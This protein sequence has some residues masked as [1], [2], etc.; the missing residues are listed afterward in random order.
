MMVSSLAVIL[1]MRIDVVMLRSMKG[2]AAALQTQVQ[3]ATANIFSRPRRSVASIFSLINAQVS[4]TS[5]NQTTVFSSPL[6]DVS[7]QREILPV[8]FDKC[9]TSNATD[10]PG[11]V[12]I[13]TAP[14]AVLATLPG[15]SDYVDV[16]LERRPAPNSQEAADP[17]YATPTWLVTDASLKPETLQTS[18]RYITSRSQ[19]YRVHSVGYFDGPGPTVRIEAVIDTNGGKPRIIYYR[20]LT[21]LGQAYGK[22]LKGQ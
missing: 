18:E 4:V 10:L 17:V 7:K 22:E 13:N 14:R 21:E 5:N 19:V 1:Y 16:L 8:L 9:T 12:N 2:D 15:L 20:D 11:R 6:M 3:R